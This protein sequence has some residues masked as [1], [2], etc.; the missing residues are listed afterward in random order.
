MRFRI[1]TDGKEKVFQ[2]KDK[3][4]GPDPNIRRLKTKIKI[5]M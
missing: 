1:Q 3:S 5:I 2:T 4:K